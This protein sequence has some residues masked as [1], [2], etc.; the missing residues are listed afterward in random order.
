LCQNYGDLEN[1]RN[2]WSFSQN[3][4]GFEK[5]FQKSGLTGLKPGPLFHVN[6]RLLDK[7]GL[8]PKNLS[9]GKA[10]LDC[11]IF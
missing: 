7:Q 1:F 6:L 11:K 9:F 2:I 8:S 5:S 4:V 10:S 3:P